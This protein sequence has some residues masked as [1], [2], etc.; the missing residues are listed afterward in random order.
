MDSDD[1]NH[2]KSQENKGPVIYLVTLRKLN[3][4]QLFIKGG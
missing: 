3:Y 1:Q 4:K 2:F